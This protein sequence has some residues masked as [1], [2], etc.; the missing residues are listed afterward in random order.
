MKR[1]FSL[2]LILLSVIML[3][4]VT[5]VISAA[6]EENPPAVSSVT[7]KNTASGINIKWSPSAGTDY[8]R[9]MRKSEGSEYTLLDELTGKSFTDTTVL[10]GKS[11][12]YMIIPCST[13]EQGTASEEQTLLRL[14]NPV[15][16]KA[17]NTTEGVKVSW[18]KVTGA[19][20]YSLYY[21][22]EGSTS[23]K[24]IL[25]V[26]NVSSA[27]DKKAASGKK[28]TYTVIARSGKAQSSFS[29]AGISLDVLATP[30]IK[31]ISNLANGI[32]FRWNKTEGAE[33]YTIYRRA[34]GKKWSYLTSVPATKASYTDTTM[35]PGY[36]YA[37]TVRAVN[38]K[39]ESAYTSGMAYRYIPVNDVTSVKP[40]ADSLKISWKASSYA[41]SYKLYRKADGESSWKRIATLKGK[42]TVSYTDKKVKDG[43]TYTYTL[44][45]VRGK[46]QSSFNSTG[47]SYTFVGVPEMTIAHKSAKGYTV[48][49]EKTENATHYYIYRR[50]KPTDS[51][52]KLARV[53]N[54]ST[55]TDK[56]ADNR[57]PY[58]YCVR[59][60][61]DGKFYSA[62]GE[63]ILSTKINPNGKMV[64]LTYDDGPHNTYT[65]SILDVLEKYDASATFF[66]VGSRLEYGKQPLQRA[67]DLGCEIGSHTY[68]HINLPSYSDS[69]IRSEMNKT[70]ALVEKYTGV[71]PVIMRPPGGA[72]SSRALAATGKPAIM[73]S[74]DTR[75]WEHRTASRTV[76][77]IKS[78][79][80]DG[81]IILMHDL[82]APTASATATIVP[83]LINNGYQL[84]T[85]SELMY[86]R[87][88]TMKPGYVYR[89]AKP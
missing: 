39:T 80:F 20:S 2:L 35:D 65:N 34:A 48:N 21:K 73:W 84:V 85:V 58:Y 66:V 57:K 40:K 63:G 13:E 44:I 62:Y 3:V 79:V 10:S 9:V 59:A 8:C 60:G 24:R 61:K 11:Y 19:D 49:W 54:V 38:S 88:V 50:E 14:S 55:Y 6:E 72:T 74:V 64:A 41:D 82:Y 27:V 70:D 12:T 33:S 81:A 37:Y 89:S 69:Q 30:E 18:Q 28:C 1:R 77:N 67:V 52:V 29:S 32:A 47:K 16:I 71:T 25:N 23:W 75:D 56:S 22:T 7:L 4:S 68:N 42:K 53:G 76:S 17:E 83:W 87:G 78:S 36:T 45:T 26:G 46:Y 51:W 31:N 86:Y 5:A 43:I 15:L